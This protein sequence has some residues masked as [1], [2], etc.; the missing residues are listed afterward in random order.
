MTSLNELD[1]ELD[2]YVIGDLDDI[3]PDTDAPPVLDGIEQ[4]D[5]ALRKVQRLGY[6]GNRIEALR[7]ARIQQ[8]RDWADERLGVLERQREFW[9]RCI[10]SWTRAHHAETGTKTVKLPAG[11]VSLRSVP[12]KVDADPDKLDKA[13]PS[14]IR[15][16]KSWDRQAV[17]NFTSP[18]PEP[19]EETDTHVVYA[20]ITADGE[21]VDGVFHLVAKVPSFSLRTEASK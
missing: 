19:M 8:I 3:D 14:L 18:S 13:P 11:T 6:E 12:V 4:A 7:D 16:Q 2:A 17:K 15:T 5:R 10:E 21:V 1:A 9:H 20:A